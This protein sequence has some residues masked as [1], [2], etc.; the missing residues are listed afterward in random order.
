MRILVLIASAAVLLASC[1]KKIETTVDEYGNTT[2]V[3][4]VGP[5]RER[6]DSTARKVGDKIEVAAEQTGAALEET[7]AQLKESLDK[8]DRQTTAERQR[9]RRDSAR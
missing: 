1:E 2:T 3:E 4:T 9:A 8:T 7:G 6:I 5:D